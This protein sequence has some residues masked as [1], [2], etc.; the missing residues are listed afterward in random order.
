MRGDKNLRAVP[1]VGVGAKFVGED[2]QEFVIEAVLRF[3]N[4]EKRGRCRVFEQQEVGEYFERSVRYLLGVKG[5]LKAFV[6][7]PE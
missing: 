4:T 2:F 7:E 1:A 6:I 3:L 5:G